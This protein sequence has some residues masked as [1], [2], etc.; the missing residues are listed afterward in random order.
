VI[1]SR[2]LLSLNIPAY[3]TIA[4][5][6]NGLIIIGLKINKNTNSHISALKINDT[7]ETSD[8]LK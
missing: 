2:P 4:K 6:I 7:T 1:P 5:Q 3:D 8:N